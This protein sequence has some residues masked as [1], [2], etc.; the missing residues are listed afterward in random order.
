MP[1]PDEVKIVGSARVGVGHADCHRRCLCA[2]KADAFL[3]RHPGKSWDPFFR[4]TIA[5]RLRR[6][7]VDQWVRLSPG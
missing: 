2:T 5:Q 6:V 4:V 7:Q 1:P 3:I